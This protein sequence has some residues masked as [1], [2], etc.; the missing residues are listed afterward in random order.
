MQNRSDITGLSSVF[1]NLIDKIS[2]ATSWA[3]TRETPEKIAVNTYI[4]EVKNSE[5][6]ALPKAAL[7]YGARKAIKEY[8]NQNDVIQKA[9]QMLT[10]EDHAKEIDDSWI[11][12]Y[13]DKIRLVSDQDFQ[14]LWAK[15]LAGEVEHPG[16]FSLRTLEKLQNLNKKEAEIFQK[17]ARLCV[18]AGQRN[19]LFANDD[20]LKRHG[21]DFS[22][23]IILE[24]CGLMNI[25]TL[26]LT[27]YANDA[28]RESSLFNKNIIGVFHSISEKKDLLS[29]DIYVFSESGREL[30]QAIKSVDADD[31][32]LIDML[33]ELKEKFQ[34]EKQEIE[35][36]AHK[37]K[38]MNE[39]GGISYEQ[40]DLLADT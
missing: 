14:L 17:A 38:K 2:S 27:L 26:N 40:V 15:I 4:E 36:S 16:T 28:A 3:F 10:G 7:I 1:N 9:A 37:I 22:D 18:Q 19:F 31:S 23:L 35:I 11:T 13:M 34:N 8:A 21:L 24:E 25:Q 33:I 5:L 29:I 39:N 12:N 32:Y 30:M 6:P 20:L